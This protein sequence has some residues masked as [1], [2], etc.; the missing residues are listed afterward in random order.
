[1]FFTLPT[2]STSFYILTVQTLLHSTL[3]PVT[4]KMLHKIAELLT[5]FYITYVHHLQYKV[6]MLQ[7]LL[8]THCIS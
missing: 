5:I 6:I 4:Y 1:M 8:T 3:L 7:Y 2:Y